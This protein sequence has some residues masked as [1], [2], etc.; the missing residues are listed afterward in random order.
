MNS[1]VIFHLFGIAV[2]LAIASVAPFARKRIRARWAKIVLVTI[3]L[4]G[5]VDG[6]L[7]LLREL[8]WFT[9]GFP[10]MDFVLLSLDGLVLGLFVALALTGQ[11]F[12]KKRT[13][14]A[15]AA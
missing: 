6:T 1:T 10:T 3:G 5:A 9:L 14:D 2:F 12:G 4:A 11:L 7:S 8:R 15:P 13:E